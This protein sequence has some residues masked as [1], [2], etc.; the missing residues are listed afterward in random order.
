LGLERAICSDWGFGS[1]SI[2]SSMNVITMKMHDRDVSAANGQV[3]TRPSRYL[4]AANVPTLQTYTLI[5][6]AY[7]AHKFACLARWSLSGLRKIT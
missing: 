5:C 4:C 6:R 7:F 3:S 1:G 2:A